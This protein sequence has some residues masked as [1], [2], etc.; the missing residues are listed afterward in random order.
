VT[1]GIENANVTVTTDAGQEINTTTEADGSYETEEAIPIGSH[2]VEV[3]ADG[4]VTV[5][6]TVEFE[7]DDV[8]EDFGLDA[9]ASV[10]GTL[11]QEG[12]EEILVNDARVTISAEGDDDDLDQLRSDGDGQYEFDAL[13]P[14]EYTIL[15]DDRNGYADTEV[16]VE[17]E[18]GETL[19][20][21]IELEFTG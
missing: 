4:Y 1:E 18:A 12:D 10:S 3:E 17:L 6:D 13:S 15:V 21:D 16:T 2:D 5:S 8:E 20:R 11:R 7:E 9:E 19:E 14:G